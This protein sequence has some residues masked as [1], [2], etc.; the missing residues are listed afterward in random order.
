MFSTVVNAA[1]EIERSYPEIKV[2]YNEKLSVH[3]SFRIG[4]RVAAMFMPETAGELLQIVRA[5]EEKGI[6]PYILGNGTNILA[7]GEDMPIA[8]IKTLG[9]CTIEQTGENEITAYSG[10]TLSRTAM[11]A[12]EKGLAGLEFAHG[13]PGSVGGAIVM[14]A[15]AYGG[16]IKDVVKSVTVCGGGQVYTLEKDE[17]DLSYR[18]SRFSDGKEIVLA[19]VFSLKKGDREQIRRSIS[20]LAAKRR[21]SQPLDKPSAGSTFKRPANGYAAAMIEQAGLRGLTV[22]GAQVS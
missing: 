14:N 8:V 3:T 4:G 21:A 17:L 7:S 19:A 15:G 16:E 20:E 10:A 22:G 2:S 9:M 6:E 5:L 13:I 12:M 1:K 11:Y 18:H